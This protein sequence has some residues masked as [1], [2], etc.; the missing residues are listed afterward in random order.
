MSYE[1]FL[2]LPSTFVDDLC[3][4]VIFKKKY[5]LEMTSEEK[6][7]TQHLL[8][9]WKEMEVNQIKHQLE[10]CLEIEE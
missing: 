5:N 9:Y 8:T 10:K 7:L 6:Q 1:E 2:D 3:R 4:L